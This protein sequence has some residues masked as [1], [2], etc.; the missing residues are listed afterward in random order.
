VP[1]DSTTAD[2]DRPQVAGL[3]VKD[4]WIGIYNGTTAMRLVIGKRDSDGFSGEIEY[5]LK[6]TVTTV[7][8]RIFRQEPGEPVWSALGETNASRQRVAVTFKE[9]GYRVENSSI[10][11]GG[12]Y[13]AYVSGTELQG[14]W[15][16]DGGQLVGRLTLTRE[17]RRG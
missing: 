16:S 3:Q 12:E 1:T 9:T 4:V 2:V 14:A 17:G 6:G 7:E 13:R 11:F 10:V 15:F 5:P 8:G